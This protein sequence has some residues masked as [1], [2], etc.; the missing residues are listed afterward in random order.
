MNNDV[1]TMCANV[2]LKM[3]EYLAKRSAQF[4]CGFFELLGLL[5]IGFL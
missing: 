2:F 3:K 1:F 5:S 4:R